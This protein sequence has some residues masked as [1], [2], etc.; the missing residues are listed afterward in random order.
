MFVNP[1]QT[2]VMEFMYTIPTKIGM[3]AEVCYIISKGPVNDFLNT[4]LHV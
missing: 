3:F 2:R 4:F 1:Y